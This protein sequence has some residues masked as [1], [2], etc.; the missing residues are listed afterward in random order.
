MVFNPSETT[1]LMLHSPA[2]EEG[3]H[4][5]SLSLQNGSV[6]FA[7]K[8]GGAGVTEVVSTATGVIRGDTWYHLFATRSVCVCVCVSCSVLHLGRERQA[9]CQY[10]RSEG[11]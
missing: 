1:G 11:V 3:R 2:G 6:A 8:V 10:H 5:L 7:A 4:A 9:S